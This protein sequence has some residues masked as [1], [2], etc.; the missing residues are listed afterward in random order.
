MEAKLNSKKL[1]R[2]VFIINRTY[3]YKP[4]IEETIA[5]KQEK[6]RPQ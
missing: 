1:V 6:Y 4:N 3:V 5:S 2:K